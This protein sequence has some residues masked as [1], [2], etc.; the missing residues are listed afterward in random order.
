MT[1]RVKILILSAVLLLLFAVVLASSMIM[2]RHSSDKVAAIIEFQ[3]PLAAAIS[4]LDVATSDY[5]LHLERML[6]RNDDSP[7]AAEAEHEALERTKARI[8]A[9]FARAESLLDRALVDPRTEGADR[10]V[11]A[12]VQRSLSYLKRLQAP[13]FA[14]GEEVL[15]RPHRR[16]GRRCARPVAAVR[17]VRAGVQRGP[18]R[19][20]GRAGHAG[21]RPRPR[22]PTRRSSA[23]SAST[24]SSSRWRWWWASASAPRARRAWSGPSGASSKGPRPS[25]RATSRRGCR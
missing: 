19:G 24:W 1:V 15:S 6:R 10:L 9:D 5:E 16:P 8:T 20:A 7:A 18:A 25:R 13:F 17:A 3:L 2:Q 22:A 11:L 4:D 23:S 21:P 12:R 14:L